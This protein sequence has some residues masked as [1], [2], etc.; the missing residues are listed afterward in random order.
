M[1]EIN[2]LFTAFGLIIESEIELPE[3]ITAKGQAKA[4]IVWGQVPDQL[5]TPVE[6]TP[7]FEVE[8]GKFLLTV[9]GIA[10]YY[11]E[12]GN[13]IVIEPHKDANLEDVRVFL[14]NTALAA[15]LKQKGYLV[16]HGAAAVVKG[17]AVA[18]VGPSGA[19]KTSIALNLL[20]RGYKL[21][22]DEICAIKIQNGKPVIFPSMPQLNVWRDTL[23][24]EGKDVNSCRPIRQGLAKYAVPIE[25]QF[26]EEAMELSS[27]VLLTH[28]NQETILCEAV[29]GGEKL[30]RLVMNSYFA[31]TVV[32]KTQHFKTCAAALKAYILQVTYNQHPYQVGKITDYI[33]KELQ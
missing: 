32:D 1:K 10:K 31:E 16:V 30:K 33:L 3:L 7:W 8:A 26:A 15:L 23:L 25:N 24:A 27:I 6:K 5:K 11:V 9:E 19:G 18:F 22:T 14:L 13:L 4:A 28:H 21:L 12:N 20:D 2:K 29:K 17:K